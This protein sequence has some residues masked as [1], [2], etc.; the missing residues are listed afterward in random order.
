MRDDG[1]GFDPAA[2]R[3]AALLDGHIGLASSE[4]RVRSAGGV[5]VVR[6]RPGGGTTVRVTL[7]LAPEH[8]AA[9]RRPAPEH[10]AP[11]LLLV[12]CAA[13][14]LMVGAVM[15][16]LWTDDA[17][18][19]AGAVVLLLA[20]LGLVARRHAAGAARRRRRRVRRPAGADRM[21]RVSSDARRAD[22]PRH[23]PRG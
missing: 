18:V 10:A 22:D 12:F 9:P 14:A 5:L 13:T 2:R 8:A 1:R 23:R 6:S 17:W 16:V 20:L 19:D 3:A 4:Q 11:G 7:P 15:L 21:T